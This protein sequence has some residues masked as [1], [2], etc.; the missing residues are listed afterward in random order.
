ML[1]LTRRTG[2]PLQQRETTMSA[3]LHCKHLLFFAILVLVGPAP[4]FAEGEQ[5]L[6]TQANVM[7]ELAFE[8][9]QN[10]DDHFNTVTL[11]VVFTDPKGQELRVPASQVH[12]LLSASTLAENAF[13]YFSGNISSRLLR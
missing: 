7:A 5:S 1:E 2:P 12:F 9:S 4:V 11:D 13:W 10:H 6:A 3:R 8:A